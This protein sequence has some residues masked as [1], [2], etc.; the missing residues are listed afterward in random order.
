MKLAGAD[1]YRERFSETPG[2]MHMQ[3]L[4]L[5]D[6]VLAAQLDWGIVGDLLEIGTYKGKS[7]IIMGMGLRFNEI[8]I[9]ND[10]FG[11]H[12]DRVSAE[13]LDA[14]EGLDLQEFKTNYR[15]WHERPPTIHA[16]PSQ[17][18]KG[19]IDAESCRFI[20]VDGGHAYQ[21]V[22]DD[23]SMV[24]HFAADHCV[25]V[26]DD[27]RTDHTPG[28]AAA[29]WGAA[30]QGMI[31]PFGLSETK[32]YAAFDLSSYEFWEQATRDRL[33][34]LYSGHRIF[35]RPVHRFGGWYP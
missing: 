9:V 15:K 32:M 3:D 21:V 29:L 16:C 34:P 22:A 31:Y 33:G 6:K 13:G 5:F 14:Y 10:L 20:H 26:A 7:A 4:E 18:L 1:I 2:W 23:L 24:R 19:Q 28:V 8:L 11:G 17:E 30:S 25:L 35:G 12:Q 27:Y